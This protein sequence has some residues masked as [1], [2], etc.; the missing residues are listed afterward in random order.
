MQINQ[1]QKETFNRLLE[2]VRTEVNLLKKTNRELERENEKLRQKLKK[3][4]KAQTD[5]F[6]SINESER[7]A[8]RHHVN[9]LI[10][11]IDKYLDES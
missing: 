4:H 11:K 5:I 8:M 7:M 2:Q 3:V 1:L 9:G 10:Q 6:S